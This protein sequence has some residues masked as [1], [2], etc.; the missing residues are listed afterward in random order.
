MLCETQKKQMVKKFQSMLNLFFINYFAR[1]ET[2]KRLECVLYLN[3]LLDFSCHHVLVQLRKTIVKK[4]VTLVSE[5]YR[6]GDDEIL[7]R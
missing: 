5:G 3:V 2:I 6:E 4:K 7:A 1:K